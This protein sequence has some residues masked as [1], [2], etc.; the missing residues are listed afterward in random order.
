MQIFSPVDILAARWHILRLAIGRWVPPPAT[1]AHSHPKEIME[2]KIF[3]VSVVL[4]CE[5]SRR[6]LS[7]KLWSIAIWCNLA[8]SSTVRRRS[9]QI[10]VL[11]E[12]RNG[13]INACGDSWTWSAAWSRNPRKIVNTNILR[14]LLGKQH[15]SDVDCQKSFF[16]SRGLCLKSFWLVLADLAPVCTFAAVVTTESIIKSSVKLIMWSTRACLNTT[17][18]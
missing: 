13:T 1:R 3:K 8:E 18:Q 10:R 7:N 5:A 14:K 4:D 17:H 6:W 15:S 11:Q 12:N 16:S 9:L 2:E